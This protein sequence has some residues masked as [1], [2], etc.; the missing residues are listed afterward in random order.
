MR[1][2]YSG[3]AAAY[4]AKGDFEKAL[5]DQNT[6]TMMYAVEAEVL[7]EVREPDRGDLFVE[8]ARA[9][10]VRS[11]I[12][13]AAGKDAAAADDE[14]RAAKLEGDGKQLTAQAAAKKAALDKPEQPVT[15]T[16]TD[17]K[18]QRENAEPKRRG[19]RI[20]R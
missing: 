3:R 6:V 14:K 7:E 17:T 18:D 20:F 5:S 8:A 19:F 11:D 4:F 9:Y 13:R 10:R 12:L 2:A 16:R 1:T 15:T